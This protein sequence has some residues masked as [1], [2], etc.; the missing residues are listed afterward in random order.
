MF[1]THVHTK[2]STDSS[3]NVESALQAAK[4][5]RLSLIITEHMDIGYPDKDQFS[6]NIEDYFKTYSQFRGE[7]LLLGIEIGM[8]EDCVKE[9]RLIAWDNPF[10][11]IIG[12]IHLV[13]NLDLYY[14]DFY[15]EKSKREAYEKY[16]KTMYN[17]LKKFDFIDSLAHM[18]YICR[19]AKYDNKELNYEEFPDIID[20]ILKLIISRGKC[21]ELNTRRLGSKI[22]AENLLKI[23][24]R[25]RELGG[26]YITVGSDA[27]SAKNIGSN[28]DIALEITKKCNLRIVYFKDREM[29]Y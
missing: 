8:K 4:D 22:A 7:T 29:E 14:D 27:H 3:M 11:Y 2:F 18:D 6:F 25:Y 13:D 9:S 5:K 19:Y 28:F 10:D 15:R 1:D 20:E 12:A 16:L 21:I 17:N 24:N 26:R 23:Y